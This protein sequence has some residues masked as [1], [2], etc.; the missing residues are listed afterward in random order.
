LS[1]PT[2]PTPPSPPAQP[3]QPPKVEEEKLSP[4]Q[5]PRC[6]NENSTIL[7]KIPVYGGHEMTRKCDQCGHVWKYKAEYGK[8]AWP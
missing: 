8:G 1:D 3:T 4:E 5:C 6:K 7:R 2:P